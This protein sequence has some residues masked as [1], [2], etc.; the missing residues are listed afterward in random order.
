MKFRESMKVSSI[1]EHPNNKN[2]FADIKDLSPALWEAMKTDISE[3]GVLVPL[4]VN[5]TT[6]QVIDGNQRLKAC[7]ELGIDTVPC[8]L[9]DPGTEEIE[10]A[11]A[12]TANNTRRPPDT[13]GQFEQ[14]AKIRRSYPSAKAGVKGNGQQSAIKTA[15]QALREIFSGQAIKAADIYN[16][17]NDEQKIAVLDWYN[18]NNP[19]QVAMRAKLI[20][21]EEEALEAEIA[22]EKLE[23]R[24][25][26][27]EESE[28]VYKKIS[29]Q[30]ESE[31]EDLKLELEEVEIIGEDE[32]G[33]EWMAEKA[34]LREQIKKLERAKASLEKKIQK[35]NEPADISAYLEGC[36]NRQKETNAVLKEV[37][38]N[39]D[40]LAVSRMKELLDSVATTYRIIKERMPDEGM[41][42]IEED[43]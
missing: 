30:K 37:L 32:D 33:S 14:M 6:K 31:I 39:R 3:F 1:T 19:T 18:E 9:V 20:E 25:S 23:Q 5:D 12:L 29:E 36:I 15:S 13:F 2:L 40:V 34:E 21:M 10:E 42:L 4:M 43:F 38:D 24:V 17:M 41:K 22:L 7:I 16:S 35:I 26:N 28:E 27:A 11:W 8:V